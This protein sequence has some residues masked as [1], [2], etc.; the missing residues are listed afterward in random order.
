[1]VITMLLRLCSAARPSPLTPTRAFSTPATWIGLP[2]TQSLA[3][4]PPCVIYDHRAARLHRR[5][6]RRSRGTVCG[7]PE[8]STFSRARRACD[9]G[10][11]LTAHRA[12]GGALIRR[13]VGDPQRS[14]PAFRFSPAADGSSRGRAGRDR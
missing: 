8:L 13:G 7:H 10:C 6:L 5:V 3:A 14:A 12:R 9:A 4:T 1:T 11:P 2:R